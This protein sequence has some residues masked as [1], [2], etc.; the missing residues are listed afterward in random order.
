MKDW[1]KTVVFSGASLGDAIECINTT[2]VQIALVLDE[3][4]RLLGT[5]T[6][7]DIRRAVLRGQGLN[8]VVNEVMNGNP[9]TASADATREE[10]LGIMRRHTFHHLP[11]VDDERKVVGLAALDSLVGIVSQENWVVLMAGGLGKRLMPLTQNCP[12]P[13]LTIGGRPILETILEGFAEQ[14]FRKFFLSVNYKAELIQD[15][16]ND[17]SKWGVEI[18]YLHEKKALGTAGAL[19]LLPNRPDAPMIV[20][21]GDLLTKLNFNSILQFHEQNKAIATMAVRSHEYQVPYGVVQVNDGSIRA[22]TEKPTHSFFVSAGIYV[23]SPDVLSHI[24]KDEFF[25]MPSLYQR[26]LV[27]GKNVAA[28]QMNDYW[29]DIGRMHDFERA[30][31]EYRVQFA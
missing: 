27:E 8:T 18:E 6:D 15:H 22:I 16:F 4:G 25:D 9:M 17:G 11:L 21:N 19:S 28:Y 31:E 10:L 26:L 13:M 29:L 24:P 30:Q 2:A 12:K 20:M 5:L 14:G 23:L 1:K 3:T 7:G